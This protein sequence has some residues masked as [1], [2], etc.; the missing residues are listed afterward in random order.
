MISH[1]SNH[2]KL[3]LYNLLQLKH[4]KKRGIHIQ[5]LTKMFIYYSAQLWYVM[6]FNL[7]LEWI[8][9]AIWPHK[10]GSS[11]GNK[12]SWPWQWVN[13]VSFSC[14]LD[15]SWVRWVNTMVKSMV[16]DIS[17][18][19]LRFQIWPPCAE[20]SSKLPV[21]SSICKSCPTTATALL[22]ILITLT[23]S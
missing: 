9:L 18:T 23:D 5:M 21:D 19:I 4:N 14:P 7:Q 20:S 1:V 10:H 16:K 15:Q 8:G 6:V 11:C 13:N 22:T 3:L 12:V 17:Y 2:N